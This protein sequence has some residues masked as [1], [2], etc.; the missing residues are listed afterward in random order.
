[1]MFG[2]S[3]YHNLKHGKV[4]GF[5]KNDKFVYVLFDGDKELTKV[6]KSELIEV[7]TLNQIDSVPYGAKCMHGAQ[8]K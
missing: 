8:R 4:K 3:V 7:K 5:T 6:I 2:D 1:M